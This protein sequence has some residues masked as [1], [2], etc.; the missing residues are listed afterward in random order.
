M[1]STKSA[2]TSLRSPSGT[3]REST[4][5]PNEIECTGAGSRG[6]TSPAAWL[7]MALPHSLQNREPGRLS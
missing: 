1:M 4:A 2:V 5:P 6:L 3:S 7:L